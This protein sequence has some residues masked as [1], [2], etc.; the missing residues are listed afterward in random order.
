M[1]ARA[2]NHPSLPVAW[3]L[4]GSLLVTA[5]VVAFVC[6]PPPA[7]GHSWSA[8]LSRATLYLLV[9]GCV[10]ALAVWGICRV[11]EESEEAGLPL[12]WALIWAA[13]I[14]VVWLPLVALLTAEH[15]PWVA[16]VLPL[17][18]VFATLLL[19][20]RAMQVEVDEDSGEGSASAAAPFQLLDSPFWRGLL[21]AAGTS[22][23]AQIGVALLAG[24]HAWGAGSLFGLGMVYPLWRWLGHGVGRR[25]WGRTS[26]GNSAVVWLLL[27]LAMVPFM[28]L[29]GAGAMSSLLG[30]RARAATMSAPSSFAH[31]RSSGYSSVILMM[32]KKPHEIVAPT[33]VATSPSFREPHVIAFDGAY[34]Y[35]KQPD[36]RPAPNARVMKGDPTQRHIFS[37]DQEP[38]MMEAHQPLGRELAMSCC[39][40]LR[41]D[42]TNADN[43]PGTIAVEVLLR[44]TSGAKKMLMVSLGSIVLPSSAVSPM[45]LKRAPVADKVTFQLP[46][47]RAGMKFDEIIVRLK[48][49]RSRSLAGTQVAVK[50]FVLVP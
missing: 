39:S 25:G 28:A 30:I 5:A 49:E 9:A 1:S 17:T 40:S 3:P 37:T 19:K 8:I 38:L 50:D 43:V 18:A 4:A 20:W 16:V 46:H 6:G 10:H 29:I 47:G 26:A 27:V 21:P 34:W 13:W 7:H 36:T 35:F 32:P 44:D 14:V 22:V 24:G 48:P 15:S 31:S 2:T 11:R 42:V 12:I 33:P 23:A 45:P 41:V